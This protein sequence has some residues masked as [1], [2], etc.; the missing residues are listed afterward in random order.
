MSSLR[1]AYTCSRQSG[2]ISET[3]TRCCIR[4]FQFKLNR[5][6]GRKQASSVT[7]AE[8]L[9]VL[10]N[11]L[12]AVDQ[13]QDNS[14]LQA[15]IVSNCCPADGWCHRRGCARARGAGRPRA[16]RYIDCAVGRFFTA[17]ADMSV[18]DGT[19][20]MCTLQTLGVITAAAPELD[21]LPD[22]LVE[23]ILEMVLRPIRAVNSG[24]RAD[25]AVR[26]WAALSAVSK[27]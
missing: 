25:E 8:Q 4:A 17:I 12:V 5:C 1:T 15:D 11:H 27:R 22:H 6:V 18:A 14:K 23:N 20:K 19:S 9:Q 10:A 26:A 21:S 24:L 7:N 2:Q 3:V 13:A 16:G